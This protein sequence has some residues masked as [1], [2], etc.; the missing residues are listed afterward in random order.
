[1]SREIKFRAWDEVTETMIYS[2]KEQSEYWFSFDDKYRFKAW[3][4]IMGAGSTYEPPEPESYELSAVM[5]YTGRKDKNGVEIY[6]G[7]ICKN[8]DWEEDA[9]AWNCRIEVIEWNDCNSAWLGWNENENGMCCE[10]IGNRHTT[11]E[12]LEADNNE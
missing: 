7:D 2:D 4:V 6:Q 12:L 11:P 1:M 3:G 9:H 8:G 10:V 5:Q